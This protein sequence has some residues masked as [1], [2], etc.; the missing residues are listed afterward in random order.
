VAQERDF[1]RAI[2]EE[3]DE[4]VHRLV[5]ADWVDEHD[6]PDRAHFIR[7]QVELSLL[8]DDSP[9]RRQLAFQC[10]QLLEA[11]EKAWLKP[12]KRLTPEW[13]WS[14]GFI[15]M[16]DL[17]GGD[18]EDQARKLFATYPLRRLVVAELF[19]QV[20]TLEHI[21]PDNTLAALDLIGN[22]LDARALKK[23]ARFKHLDNLRELGLMFNRLRDTAIDV[24]CAEPFFQRLSLIRLGA[25]PFSVRGRQRLQDHFGPRVT[26][27]RERD[28]ERLYLFQ[29]D[30]FLV[31]FGKELTQFLVLPGLQFARVALFDHAGNLLQT[32]TRPVPQAD[33]GDIQGQIARWV[34]VRDA[35]LEE[36]GYQS[37]TI[38]V[39][40]FRF[41][42]GVGINDFN[43]WADVFN[44][45]NDSRRADLNEALEQWL[46]DGQFEF[47]WGDTNCWLDRHGVVTD[48]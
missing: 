1:I 46:A 26:F 36:L 8:T 42:D 41:A 11:N 28:P 25:N 12:L 23:L 31:G 17:P 29:D 45:R 21:P 16:I 47:T 32:E 7:A 44:R 34:E 33:W 18:L 15:E 10:R 38:K 39:K 24:L 2:V 30:E 22:E 27:A 43:W 14:R 40:R 4:D 6:Q 37:A 35:W 20:D 13:R 19:G 5:Y 48:T 3:P 9:R